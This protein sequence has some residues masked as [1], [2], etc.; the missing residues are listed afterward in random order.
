MALA[1][2]K[3]VMITVGLAAARVLVI[4]MVVAVDLALIEVDFITKGLVTIMEEGSVEQALAKVTFQELVEVLLLL[5]S[6]R[7]CFHL[8]ILAHRQ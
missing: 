5:R 4:I 2:A 8:L 3:E 7:F 6:F 1:I